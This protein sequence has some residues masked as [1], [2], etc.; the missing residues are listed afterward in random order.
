[1]RRW[2]PRKGHSLH[3]HKMW[4]K[5][6]DCLKVTSRPHFRFPGHWLSWEEVPNSPSAKHSTQAQH[7]TGPTGFPTLLTPTPLQRSCDFQ[8]APGL[9]VPNSWCFQKLSVTADTKTQTALC[10]AVKFPSSTIR[11]L[12][13][14]PPQRGRPQVVKSFHRNAKPH[15]APNIAPDPGMPLW[16]DKGRQEVCT[17]SLY[18][19]CLTRSFYPPLPTKRS[20]ILNLY[21]VTC[22]MGSESCC[23]TGDHP[24]GNS[25]SL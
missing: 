9:Q 8:W 4:C 15:C 14:L 19:L 22:G 2:R 6:Q 20:L 12:S 25:V 18:W 17:F 3:S 21:D 24:D 7:L 13:N 11:R 5:G 23:I 10:Q 1:M 16:R